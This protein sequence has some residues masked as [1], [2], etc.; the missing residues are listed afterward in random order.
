MLKLKKEGKLPPFITRV[1]P[2]GYRKKA[3]GRT[4]WADLRND[5]IEG[6]KLV[7]KGLGAIGR[8]ETGY[9]GIIHLKGEQGRLE[10]RY[11]P[12]RRKW[13]AHISFKATGKAVRGEWSIIPSG[14]LSP[15]SPLET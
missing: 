11:N 5:Q 14:A 15:R 8:I 4:L 2:P 9:R 12:D 1:S 10:I 3:G 7:L 6:G 13:Y